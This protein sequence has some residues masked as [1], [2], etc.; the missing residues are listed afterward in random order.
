MRNLLLY[1]CRLARTDIEVTQPDLYE[2]QFYLAGVKKEI[3]MFE[4]I[5]VVSWILISGAVLLY[6]KFVSSKFIYI[7]SFFSN[8]T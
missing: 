1:S 8:C 2:V 5:L 3:T 7:P 6:R 4:L